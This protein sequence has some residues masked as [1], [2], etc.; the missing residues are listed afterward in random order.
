MKPK[1][2]FLLIGA[3]IITPNGCMNTADFWKI[4]MFVEQDYELQASPRLL[5]VRVNKWFKKRFYGTNLF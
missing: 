3:G 4:S 2:D 1:S 5:T